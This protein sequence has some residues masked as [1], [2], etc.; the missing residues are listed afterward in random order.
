MGDVVFVEARCATGHKDTISDLGVSARR[1]K[2]GLDQCSE[3]ISRISDSGEE[4]ITA[5]GE[6]HEF[7]RSCIG[8]NEW[9][10]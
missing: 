10:C 5:E 1:I 2:D 6:S 7:E 8:C 9:R 4:T 3:R